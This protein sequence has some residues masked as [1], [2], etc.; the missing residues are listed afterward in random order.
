[1]TRSALKQ[2][3]K[4]VLVISWNH[5]IAQLGRHLERY[6]IFVRLFP[7]PSLLRTNAQHHC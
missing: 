6:L 2:T 3:A 7:S 1:M 4:C 5:R